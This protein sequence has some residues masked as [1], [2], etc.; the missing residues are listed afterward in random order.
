MVVVAADEPLPASLAIRKRHCGP[1]VRTGCVTCKIRHVK[2][3]EAKP[4]C[5][6]YVG[7][8]ALSRAMNE[9]RVLILG[10]AKDV[11]RL[12]A[13]AMATKMLPLQNQGEEG[14]SWT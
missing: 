6:R 5:R 7:C 11:L 4:F 1:K 13:I 9:N 2:C 12:S 14:R 3:D 10:G 8:L